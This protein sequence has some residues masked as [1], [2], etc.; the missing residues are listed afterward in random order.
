MTLA[1]E[2][3]LYVLLRAQTQVSFSWAR[4]D[5]RPSANPLV[6]RS[7]VFWFGTTRFRFKDVWATAGGLATWRCVVGFVGSYVERG[8]GD[9]EWV[10]G[11]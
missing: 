11:R 4:L 10:G 2:M 1:L 9:E 5:R 6:L 3:L 8:G 7:M